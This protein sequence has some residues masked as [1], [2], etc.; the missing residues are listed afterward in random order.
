MTTSSSITARP[1]VTLKLATSLDG[2]I[3]TRTGESQWITCEQSRAQTHK[4]RAAHDAI[5]VGSGTVLADD[6]MLTARSDPPP[7]VQPLRIVADGRFRTPLTSKLVQTAHES[8][9]AI[10]VGVDIDDAQFDDYIRAGVEIWETPIA[11]MG[12]VSVTG[13]L[14]KCA[15]AGIDSLFLEGGGRLASSFLRAGVVDRIEWFRAPIILGGDG[16]DAVASLG[17][18]YL[19]EAPV[20]TRTELRESGPDVWESYILADRPEEKSE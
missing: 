5:I 20:F 3:A 2:R 14:S 13:V 19:S 18:E 12:G 15:E 17:L 6:P 1:T 7:A 9:V 8:P 10:C 11:P 4:L 16:L